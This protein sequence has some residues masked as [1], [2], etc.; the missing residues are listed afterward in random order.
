M[1]PKQLL[2]TIICCIGSLVNAQ[3]KATHLSG[4]V[5]IDL[6]DNQITASYKLSNIKVDNPKMSF[7]LNEEFDVDQVYLNGAPIASSKNGRYCADCKVHTI[8]I[9]RPI[10]P[11][12]IITVDVT[13]EY[14]SYSKKDLKKNLDA[15]IVKSPNLFI[16]KER[17]KWYPVIMD[18]VPEKARHQKKQAYTYALKV[19]CISC[20]EVSIANG[21]PQSSGSLF[22]SDTPTESITIMAGNLDRTQ[23]DANALKNTSSQIVSARGIE[24]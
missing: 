24:R 13:G 22:T 2:I 9:D 6:P 15:Q 12:D 18:N 20:K 11:Q 19:N 3:E 14:E 5:N 4:T 17:S 16:A 7:L 23:S 21:T 1:T 8:W 10:T